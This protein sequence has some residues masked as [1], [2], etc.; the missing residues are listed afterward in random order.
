MGKEP[1]FTV[2]N[3]YDKE[4]GRYVTNGFLKMFSSNWPKGDPKALWGR[5]DA[6]VISK[7]LADKYFKGKDP[8]GKIIRID[9]NETM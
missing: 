2:D 7:K 9:N 3:T 5:P 4:K 1:L 6:I 8:M